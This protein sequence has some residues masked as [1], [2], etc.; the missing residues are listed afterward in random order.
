MKT[1]GAVFDFLARWLLRLLPFVGIIEH[2]EA[3]NKRL[4]DERDKLLERLILLS[5]GS[6]LDG[7]AAVAG[8]PKRIAS[9]DESRFTLEQQ[10]MNRAVENLSGMS[11]ADYAAWV[12]TGEVPK[13]EIVE[14]P[15]LQPTNGGMK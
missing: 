5:T 9:W 14:T 11:V 10:S 1:W 12:E 4:T 15:P 2:L 3:E 8:T 13:H 7:A 6:G